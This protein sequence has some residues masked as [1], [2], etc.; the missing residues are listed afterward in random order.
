[1]T[2]WL[3]IARRFATSVVS[4]FAVV[5][6]LAILFDAL[7]LGRRAA[8]VEDIG[9]A[10]VIGMAALRAPS[11]SIKAAPFVMLLAAIWT[12]A[13]LARSSEL[14][15]TRA[16]GVSAWRIVAPTMVTAA[17]FGVFVTT[18]YNPVSAA[19]LDRFE[20]LQAQVFRGDDS[21]LS[22][23]REGLWLRQGN[24]DAQSVIHARDTNSD[25]TELKQV[26]I[27]LFRGTD[28]FI[29]R[30]DADAASLRA[31][32]WRLENAAVRRLDPDDPNAPPSLE[33]LASYDLPTDLTATQIVDSFAAPE[34][35]S[36]WRLYGFIQTLRE[37]GF[38]ARR[39][40]LHW[41]ASLAAPLVFAAMALLGSAFSMR[42]ARMGGL[43]IMALWAALTGFAIYFI[44]DIAQALGGS[45]VIPPA[46]AAWGPPFASLLL[47]AGLLLHFEDG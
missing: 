8:G 32:F 15:V 35:I 9:F 37:Q 29:G 34:T 38:A 30:I 14:V 43:G 17:L 7:E 16:A 28:D 33:E 18:V 2:L 4:I 6:F 47:A 21:L 26:T 40:R 39:H 46:P 10:N 42:H 1:M 41:H 44:F 27:F 25:G 23:S 12:Y 5:L 24:F 19:L 31:G 13:R 11:I 20:R 22:V 3:Y 45:G 36:I